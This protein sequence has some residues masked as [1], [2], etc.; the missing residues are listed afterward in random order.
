MDY[1]H[2]AKKLL[3]AN[4]KVTDQ[5]AEILR[6]AIYADGLFDK[7]ELAFLIELRHAVRGQTSA[8]FDQLFFSVLK[9]IILAD[10]R[11]SAREVELLRSALFADGVASPAEKALLQEL[12]REAKSFD[13]SFQVLC[14][15]YGGAGDFS[16]Q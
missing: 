12:R 1:K 11:I 4:G 9:R 8:G 16:R 10:G 7:H 13:P 15:Y 14:D 3:L 5:E 6:Q 2:L